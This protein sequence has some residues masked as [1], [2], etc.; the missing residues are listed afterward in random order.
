MRK[1]FSGETGSGNIHFAVDAKGQIKLGYLVVFDQ[2]GIE[3]TFA[4]EFTEF[5]DLATH[6][7]T[8][9]DGG[10]DG[11][12]VGNGKSSRVTE[13]DRA[14]ESVGFGTEFIGAGA[15]H[16]AGGTDLDVYFQT[17]NGFVFHFWQ[18]ILKIVK[19]YNTSLYNTTVEVIFPV[20]FKEN[21]S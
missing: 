6:E 14:G 20:D 18:K 7:Q 16:F 11:F 5:G 19:T 1:S 17:D 13:A 21:R 3:I 10:A 12:L 8:G 15:E 4:V 9:F 2:I